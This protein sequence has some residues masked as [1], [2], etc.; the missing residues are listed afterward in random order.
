MGIFSRLSDIVNSNINALLDRAEDP[1]KMVRLMVQE[2]EETLVE[3][4]TSSARAIADRKELT[5]RRDALARDVEEW[6]RKAAVAI[7]RGR[8]DL[9]RAALIEKRRAEAVLQGVADELML[10]EESLDNLSRDIAMLQ[11]KIRDAKARQQSLIRRAKTAQARIGV[12]EQLSRSTV[13]DAMLRFEAAERRMDELEGHVESFDL[14]E[15]TLSEQIADLEGEAEI[16]AELAALKA[17]VVGRDDTA[18]QSGAANP[19]ASG[20][21][22]TAGDGS[23]R[24]L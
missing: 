11:E 10:L 3:V 9:A 15:K 5:R 18:P 21:N 12:R 19:A 7:N 24:P 1:E 6:E 20:Q 2:M 13:D 22:E 8:E 4:R 23:D 17:R 14:G 16:D